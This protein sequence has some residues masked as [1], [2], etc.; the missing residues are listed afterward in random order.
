MTPKYYINLFWSEPDGVWVAD[1][2]DLRMPR[3]RTGTSLVSAHVD[4]PR[5]CPL[6]R[7]SESQHNGGPLRPEYDKDDDIGSRS[8]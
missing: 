7:C 8:D 3:S 5:P 1:A 2:P 6:L 4:S